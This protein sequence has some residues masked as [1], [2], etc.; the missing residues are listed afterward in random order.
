MNKYVFS[1]L[2]LKLQLLYKHQYQWDALALYSVGNQLC[3]VKNLSYLSQNM[4]LRSSCLI[5][6]VRVPSDK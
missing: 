1:Q 3:L 5:E 4:F 6:R 2:M